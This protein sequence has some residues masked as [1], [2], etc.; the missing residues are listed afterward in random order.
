MIQRL[1]TMWLRSHEGRKVSIPQDCVWVQWARRLRGMASTSLAFLHMNQSRVVVCT[2]S[3]PWY[4]DRPTY[5]KTWN[6]YEMQSGTRRNSNIVEHRLFKAPP[7]FVLT[8]SVSEKK[9]VPQV[10]DMFKPLFFSLLS[11]NDAFHLS[12]QR[13]ACCHNAP[14]SL[15]NA[16]PR[17]L[18]GLQTSLRVLD[19]LS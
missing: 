4:N 17:T 1:D 5:G 15:R 10:L 19:L 8:R 6:T 18:S 13:R 16:A 3:C 7:T 12:R 14:A 11:N 9:D 2:K